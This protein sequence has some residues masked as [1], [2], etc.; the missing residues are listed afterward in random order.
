MPANY[1]NQTLMK[2]EDMVN[3]HLATI[4]EQLSQAA[5]GMALATASG[6][7]FISPK[8]SPGIAVNMHGA[9][10]ARK[11]PAATPGAAH[12]CNMVCCTPL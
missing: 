12:V 2:N 10:P 4:Q 9:F 8:V 5:I 3:F 7:A 1:N 6:R 11:Q